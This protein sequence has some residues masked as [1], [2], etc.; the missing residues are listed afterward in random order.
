MF[1]IE[2]KFKLFL[3][4]IAIPDHQDSEAR[5]W[6]RKI[7]EG[8]EQRSST[9]IEKIFLSGSVK[10]RTAIS[11]LHDVDL[12]IVV[13][14]NFVSGSNSGRG[15]QNF[16]QSELLSIL[17]KNTSISLMDHGLQISKGDFQVDLVIARLFRNEIDAYNIMNGTN[18]IKTTVKDHEKRLEDINRRTNG[19]AQNYIRLL[20][21]WNYQKKKPVVGKPINSFHLEVLVLDNMPINEERY[22]EGVKSLFGNISKAVEEKRPHYSEN[23]PN[24]DEMTLDERLRAIRLLNLSYSQANNNRWDLVYGKR[25]PK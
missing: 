22:S 11:P 20:K 12:Y 15:F 8:L 7:K 16:F 6:T 18:W 13:K 5:K 4:K 2:E 17:E 9:H 14:E 1:N 25:F 10:R 24:I 21:A 19:R 3:Q 23:A